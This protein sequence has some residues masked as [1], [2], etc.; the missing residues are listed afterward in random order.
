[1]VKT[2]LIYVFVVLISNLSLASIIQ[3]TQSGNWTDSNTWI[4]G[5]QPCQTD[6][7]IIN[8]GD[9]VFINS[10]FAQSFY[11]KNK[12]VIYFK[13]H[14]NFLKC[15][16]TNFESGEITGTYLGTFHTENITFSKKSILGKCHLDVSNNV[17][18]NDSLT[19]TSANGTKYFG[20][21]TNFSYSLH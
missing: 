6:S 7:V 14:T 16:E 17:K 10:S 4:N 15:F 21:F 19:I 3:T 18:I 1:M 9:T 2:F 12:G 5:I 11:L 20:N 13:S 8:T